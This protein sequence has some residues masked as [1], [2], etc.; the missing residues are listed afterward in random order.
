MCSFTSQLKSAGQK[1]HIW[2]KQCLQTICYHVTLFITEPVHATS[3][4]S[5]F[6]LY[7]LTV[8]EAGYRNNAKPIARTD[9]LCNVL[10]QLVSA[11]EKNTDIYRL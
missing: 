6:H 4:N 3:N 5:T 7:T 8:Y 2:T 11:A 9:Q 1:W 10:R